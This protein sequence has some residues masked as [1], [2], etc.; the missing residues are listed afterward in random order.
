[1]LLILYELC[2]THEPCILEELCVVEIVPLIIHS[3]MFYIILK[4]EHKRMYRRFNKLPC[5]LRS[6]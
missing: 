3:N 4:F 2:V 6:E 5:F 1:M